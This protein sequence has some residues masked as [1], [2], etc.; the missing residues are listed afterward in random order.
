[1]H[2]TLTIAKH[3]AEAAGRIQLYYV[4]KLDRLNIKEKAINDWVS[5][6]DTKCEAAIIET[7]HKYQPYH[8]IMGEES[9]ITGEDDEHRWIV[10]PLDGTS[11]FLHGIPHFCISIAYAHRGVVQSGVVYD[12]VR[13]E[14]FMAARGKGAQLNETRIRTTNRATLSGAMIANGRTPQVDDNRPNRDLSGAL[15]VLAQKEAITRRMGA[16]ALDLAYVACGRFDGFFEHEL[17]LWDIAAG[18][19]IVQEAGGLVSDFS[20][21]QT[22]EQTGN[23]VAGSLKVFKPLLKIVNAHWES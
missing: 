6:V 4:D 14:M 18:A 23:I 10:D 21:A 15:Q 17:Q 5:E 9:G 19:L 3:A 11:N 22:H 1:M 13:K 16:A 8:Q 2:P 7:I 20:G 12:P